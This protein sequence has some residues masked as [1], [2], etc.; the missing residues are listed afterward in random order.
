[1]V[2]LPRLR[3]AGLRILHDSMYGSGYGYLH[4]LMNERGES[5]TKVAEF[6][7]DR[8]PYFG[9]VSPEPIP[10]NLEDTLALLQSGKFDLGIITDGDADRVGIID[11]KGEFVNQLQVYALLMMYLV[12][13][14]G[15]K[16]PVVKSIN[17]KY[18]R[19]RSRPT[20]HP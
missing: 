18:A 19:A 3:K 14:R 5:V 20:H 2:D 8:N 7:A 15:W 17:A 11:E 4:E 16:G 12:E 9:G 13:V 1:M 10:A 6:R